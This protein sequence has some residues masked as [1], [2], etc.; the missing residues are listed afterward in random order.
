[1]EHDWESME[2][3]MH[4]FILLLNLIVQICWQCYTSFCNE[5]VH[6]FGLSV[7][8][9]VLLNSLHTVKEY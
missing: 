7:Y 3:E 5:N 8:R 1:M 4:T 6:Y 9:V 2:L